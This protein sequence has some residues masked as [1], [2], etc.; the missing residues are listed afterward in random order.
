MTETDLLTDQ[1]IPSDLVNTHLKGKIIC[2]GI[3]VI[4]HISC[5]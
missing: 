2:I 3:L 5:K 4:S 1:L